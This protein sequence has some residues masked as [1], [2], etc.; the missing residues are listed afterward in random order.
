MV[1]G[2][3]CRATLYSIHDLSLWALIFWGFVAFVSWRVTH[4]F[5]TRVRKQ[6][7]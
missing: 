1:C 4:W 7:K 2:A 3:D 6:P 5:R